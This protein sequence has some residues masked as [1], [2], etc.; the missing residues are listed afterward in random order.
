GVLDVGGRP[1]RHGDQI[2]RGDAR[3]Q[4]P[5]HRRARPGFGGVFYYIEQDLG[6]RWRWLAILYACLAG[7]AALG[8]GN[9]V[10]ANTMAHAME[11]GFGVPPWV[12]GIAAMVLV[13]AV[14]LG[15]IRR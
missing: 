13:G 1:G 11:T 2:R 3:P 4:V 15:G 8:I 7:I 5:P 14:T 6:A 10:Q 9:M 12:T